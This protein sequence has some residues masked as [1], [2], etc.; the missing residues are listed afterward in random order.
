VVSNQCVPESNVK[1]KDCPVPMLHPPQVIV[2]KRV[3]KGFEVYC[4]YGLLSNQ[5][6]I[7]RYGFAQRNNPSDKIRIG[8][9]LSDAVGRVEIPVDYT[10]LLSNENQ[11]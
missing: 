5:D 1:V 6:V 11:V 10:P 3:C 4:C 2:H 8:W 7:L 9:T